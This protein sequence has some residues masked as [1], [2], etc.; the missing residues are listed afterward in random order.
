MQG[1]QHHNGSAVLLDWLER[2]SDSIARL[3]F[4]AVVAATPSVVV[5][6]TMDAALLQDSLRSHLPRAYEAVAHGHSD[7]PVK[8]PRAADRWAR[9]LAVAG[10]D[11]S[12]LIL[13][14]DAGRDAM[15]K[16]FVED[17]RSGPHRMDDGRRAAALESA[18]EGLADYVRTALAG[19]ISVYM[20]ERNSLAGPVDSEKRNMMLRLLAGDVAEREAEEALGYRLSA[21]HL[22]FVLWSAEPAGAQMD[23]AIPSLRNAFDAWQH[24]S[25]AVGPTSVE[26]WM[27]IRE[28]SMVDVERIARNVKLA[29]GVRIAFGSPLP[30]VEGFRLSRRQAR[31]AQRLAGRAG[32][33]DSCSVLFVDV[34]VKALLSGDAELTRAFV[35]AEIG[36]LLEPQHTVLLATLEAWTS[37]AGSPTRAARRLTVHPNTVVKRLDRI[38]RLLPRPLDALSLPLRV[39]VELAPLLGPGHGDDVVRP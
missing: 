25:V 22:A 37:E 16:S 24:L 4:D 26:G 34:A 17:M 13:A 33:A 28:Q 8:L 7:R 19:A 18:M 12:E 20:E 38:E 11:L 30:G 39:A 32:K 2:D 3:M 6:G 29:E 15:M 5:D 14:Y 27:S 36:P 31:E 1:D 23:R 9:R 10:V 21:A 35:T